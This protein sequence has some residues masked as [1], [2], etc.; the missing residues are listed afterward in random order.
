MR[1]PPRGG[2]AAR[3]RRRR[4]GRPR[5]DPRRPGRTCGTSI[6]ASRF[7]HPACALRQR[8]KQG[9]RRSGAGAVVPPCR[10]SAALRPGAPRATH[11][12]G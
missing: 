8:A 11:M 3:H 4:R 2:Q 9:A 12:Q 1:P 6:I 5:P 7:L 10:D